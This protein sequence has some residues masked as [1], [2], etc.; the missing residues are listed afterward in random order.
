M[1]CDDICWHQKYYQIQINSWNKKKKKKKGGTVA[2]LRYTILKENQILR[3]EPKN[4]VF[5]V[6]LLLND[7]CKQFNFLTK[8]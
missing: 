4:P 2:L 3:K 5:P 8:H 6:N 7:R 1:S